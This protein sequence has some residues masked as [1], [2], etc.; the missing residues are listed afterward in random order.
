MKSKKEKHHI[1][2]K[3]ALAASN[4]RNIWVYKLKISINNSRNLVSINYNLHKVLHTKAYY[5]AI[6][7]LIVN[8]YNKRGR[9]G[10]LTTV[11]L[12]KAMLAT[13]SYKGV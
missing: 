2:P 1:I 3:G 10:V 4:A 13:A 6:D 7:N 5:S 11:A 9:K 12:V 8:A